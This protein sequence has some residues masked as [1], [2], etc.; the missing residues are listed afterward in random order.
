MPRKRRHL[1]WALFVLSAPSCMLGVDFEKV[2]EPSDFCAPVGTLT[3]PPSCADRDDGCGPALA[4]DCCESPPVPCGAFKRDFDG[5]YF[6][7]EDN[8]ATLSDFRLDRF[9]VSVARFRVFIEQ[10]GGT[11]ENTPDQDDGIHPGNKNS[12]WRVAWDDQ[13]LASIDALKAALDCDQHATWTD[14]EGANESKPINCLSWY[15]AFAFCAWDGGRLPTEAEWSYAA[16]GGSEQR[17]YPW[18]KPPTSEELS[19]NQAVFGCDPSVAACPGLSAIA[20]VGFRTGAGAGR[21][22]QVDMAGNVSEWLL[23]WK[24]WSDPATGY[25]TPCDDCVEI[26]SAPSERATRGGDFTTDVDDVDYLIVSQP[27]SNCV[28]CRSSALGVRCA[29]SSQ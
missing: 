29:R 6:G 9:E 11:Q 1:P 3:I 8:E 17:V 23:D 24:D 2:E 7:D 16:A 15:E 13:L 28:D 22:G 21:W 25:I 19:E 27:D 12:G 20:Q 18:S 26:G 14:D 10:G 4:D 5:V